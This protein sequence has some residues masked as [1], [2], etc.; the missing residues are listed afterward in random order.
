MKYSI[1]Q[2]DFAESNLLIPT[3]EIVGQI[4]IGDNS[5]MIKG[6]PKSIDLV[7]LEQGFDEYKNKK[8]LDFGYDTDDL[9]SF[10][11]SLGHNEV[12]V[13]DAPYY[14]S[15]N[16]EGFDDMVVYD[17]SDSIFNWVEECVEVKTYSWDT[18]NDV[19]E[20]E[21]NEEVMTETELEV[22]E[23]FVELDEYDGRILSASEQFEHER[24]YKII[25]KDGKLVKDEFLL[26]HYSQWQGTHSGGKILTLDEVVN[27]LEEL[28]GDVSRCVH[29]IDALAGK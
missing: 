15:P 20:V 17:C 18:S 25:T 13:W 26:M 11:I 23:D 4:Y 6:L 1:W 21:F 2:T 10:L 16:E 7:A 29:A 5:W 8:E 22:S 24:I 14:M 12:E 28:N 3:D 9:K 19:E 27:H